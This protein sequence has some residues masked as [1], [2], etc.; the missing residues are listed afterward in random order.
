MGDRGNIEV[1]YETKEG[2]SSIFFYTHWSGSYI[3]EVVYNA[4][5]ERERWDDPAYLA[6]II[7][8]KLVKGDE[9]GSTGYGIAPYICDNE[10]PIVKVDTERRT[11]SIGDEPPCCFSDYVENFT[12]QINPDNL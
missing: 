10:H 12:L 8:C 7:F 6:R 5:S 11:V 4:L 9:D 3:K 1:I 2:N